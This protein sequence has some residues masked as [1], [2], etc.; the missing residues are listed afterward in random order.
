MAGRTPAPTRPGTLRAGRATPRKVRRVSV[1][2]RTGV[3]AG[4]GTL[5]AGRA[6][7]RQVRRVSVTPLTGAPAGPGTLRAGRATPGAEGVRDRPDRGAG[8]A[9]HPPCRT[10]HGPARP[11][12]RAHTAPGFHVPWVARDRTG[13][14]HAGGRPAAQVDD[15]SGRE[16]V[17]RERVRSRQK[18]PDRL[19]V[20][21]CCRQ[22]APA[23][24]GSHF[25]AA[26]G[27]WPRRS[28]Q[29]APAPCACRSRCWLRGR[30]WAETGRALPGACVRTPRP[31]G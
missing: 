31:A 30:E 18:G 10:P 16:V 6:T 20:R 25:M 24:N 23:G 7:P 29:P 9:G 19:E 21:A 5:R 15:D 17:D 13:L 26:A 28:R 22:Q 27:E 4:P 2:A 1:T 14:V 12:G 3:P 11:P 8:W